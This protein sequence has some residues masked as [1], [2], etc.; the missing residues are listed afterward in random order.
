MLLTVRG[1]TRSIRFFN[2]PTILSDRVSRCKDETHQSAPPLRR[3]NE[4]IDLGYFNAVATSRNK[5]AGRPPPTT[6]FIGVLSSLPIQTP[7]IIPLTEPMNHPS[8]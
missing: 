7:I 5:R 2:D 1:I 6:F 8:R 4:I 3:P